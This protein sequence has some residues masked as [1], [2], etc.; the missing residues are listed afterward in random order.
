MRIRKQRSLCFLAL[1]GLAFLFL[2]LRPA[3]ANA[4]TVCKIGSKKYSSLQKA[5]NAVGNGETIK[6]KKDISESEDVFLGNGKTYTIDFADHSY[7]YSGSGNNVFHV[8][9]PNPAKVTIKRW[10]VNSN[11][12]V[13]I[14]KGHSLTILSGT[15]TGPCLQ[16]DGGSLIIRG[17]T[18]QAKPVE[19]WQNLIDV[20][21]NSPGAVVEISGGTFK[22]YPGRTI[23]QQQDGLITI[24]GGSFSAD[25]ASVLSSFGTAIISGGTFR[26]KYNKEN[27]WKGNVIAALGKKMTIT[28][29]SF[30]GEIPM[31]SVLYVDS[32]STETTVK[33]GTFS[34]SFWAVHAV[35][36]LKIK[37]GT[38]KG[39]IHA[40][41]TGRVSI[42][43][44]KCTTT[45]FAQNQS[46]ITI[47]KVTVK[48]GTPPPLGFSG[49]PNPCL[50]TVEQGKIT[51]KGGSF[52]SPAGIGYSGNV[53]FKTS[54]DFKRLFHVKTLT[55]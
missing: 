46:T 19:D 42:S 15:Y 7:T 27:E 35:G 49:Q 11:R 1:L 29:G 40:A 17:G 48:Q 28:G 22:G 31:S 43:G 4:A 32:H 10:K 33:G 12:G 45:I 2:V 34:G 8:A 6:V 13:F 38:F 26:T 5:I 52:I 55:E 54:G 36:P 53:V 47:S 20:G 16:M 14:G 41:D 9:G 44:G 30:K 37:K 24:S 39:E 21:R 25:G 51:V 3:Q 18:F 50:K 23:I